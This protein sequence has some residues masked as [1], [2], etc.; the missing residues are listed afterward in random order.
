MDDNID[1]Q[2]IDAFNKAVQGLI[3]TTG[4]MNR[5][6]LLSLK[7]HQEREAAD[8]KSHKVRE[9]RFRSI[10]RNM[11]T[12]DSRFK[13]ITSSGDNAIRFLRTFA[14]QGKGFLGLGLFSVMAYRMN[15][16][17]GTWQKL[18]NHGQTF[19]GSMASMLQ[20]AGAAGLSLE[21]FADTYRDHN[22]V[23]KATDGQFF[24]MQKSLRETV[25][26]YG[27]Y[28]MTVSQLTEFMGNNLE[29]S[30]R[31]GSLQS[32]TSGEYVR[33]MNE[34][35]VTTTALAEASDKT[36]DQIME[37][38]NA[39]MSSA[40]SIAQ[41]RSLPANIRGSVTK[42]VTEATAIFASMAGESGDFFS[43]FYNDALGSTAALTSQGST[44]VAAGLSD[45]VSEMDALT[46]KFNTGQ[47]SADDVFAYQEKFRK[48]FENNL[49]VL[50]AQ[51][52]AGNEAAK[53][54][55]IYGSS[56]QNLSRADMK[57]NEENA[58][59]TKVLTAFFSSFNSVFQLLKGSL[60]SSFIKGL[61]EAGITMDK[62]ADGE[63]FKKITAM[64]EVVGDTWG[65]AFGTFISSISVKDV[66]TFL[67]DFTT[68]VLVAGEIIAG[69]GRGVGYL[70]SGVKKTSDFLH[71]IGVNLSDLAL[72]VVAT[73][74]AFKLIKGVLAV[75]NFLAGGKPVTVRGGVINVLGAAGAG[76]A[77]ELLNDAGGD[78]GGKNKK[79][80]MGRKARIAGRN[81]MRRQG[82]VG[83][84]A[85]MGGK[86]LNGT[87]GLFGKLGPRAGSLLS[88]AGQLGTGLLKGGLGALAGA[89]L[90]LLSDNMEQGTV[91]QKTVGVG[92]KAATWAGTGAMLGSVVPGL[93]TAAGGILGGGLGALSGLYDAMTS[94][95]AEEDKAKE[96]EEK[97]EKKEEEKP[98]DDTQEKILAQL[99]SN[100]DELTELRRVMNQKL[101]MANR[102]LSKIEVST[103]SI[104]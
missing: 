79:S 70:M 54:M 82:P 64:L 56:I 33:D 101:E 55:I 9:S 28:G 86:V 4:A 32:R 26:Q 88:S 99:K 80:R 7:R 84:I 38:A 91:L 76:A 40:L 92:A 51:A 50:K 103:Q 19:S 67:T 23:I 62:F 95:S 30:R 41:M 63:T 68:V 73:V 18:T 57:R 90:G 10:D 97:E 47:G 37:L 22:L 60:V 11:S 25:A 61:G 48:A 96:P 59:N 78:G 66:Q 81:L 77:G 71:G 3:G 75:R 46:R 6:M 72:G 45:M 2:S 85:R 16:L 98:R 14:E 44:M 35:A 89:G 94:P 12:M 31:N 87:A 100:N 34:L 52:I 24:S 29:V 65:K 13:E 15:E 69:F 17:A 1:T 21:E 42:S 104:S 58:K 74:A 53:Q 83:S 49:P 39:A 102:Y 8:N 36:R 27:N 5:S 43:K 93:G 20:Q